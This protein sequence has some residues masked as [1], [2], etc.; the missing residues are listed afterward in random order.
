VDDGS[1][2][3]S[4]EIISSYANKV[5]PVLK[6]NGGQASAFNAGFDAS[7]GE[8]IIF[9]DADDMLYPTA[10]E[11][12]LVFFENTQ[13]V[14]VQWPLSIVDVES[15]VST[16]IEPS[17]IDSIDS[18]P[19][20]DLRDIVIKSGPS[21]LLSPPTSGN[22]WS[23]DFLL[24]VLPMDEKVYRM[25]ADAY[26]FEL[27]P[28]VGLI[29]TVHEPQ[30]YYR[31]HG[32]NH[33]TSMNFDQKLE[34]GLRM[35]N[36]YSLV[37]KKLCEKMDIHVDFNAWQANSWWCRFKRATNSLDTIVPKGE[38]FILVDDCT[39]GMQGDSVRH[40]IPFLE[41]DGEYWGPPPDSATAIQAL[42]KLRA[43]GICF[44]VI[45]WMSF[46]WL[47]YYT[48][49]SKYLH[50]HYS[51]ILEDENLIIFDLR[52]QLKKSIGV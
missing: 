51:C 14:K 30:A 1:T 37:A 19:E 26:L 49:F 5:N 29:R 34:F 7:C 12:A 22:A 21:N 6:D 43:S 42:E 39:W 31:V 40:P 33:H 46:W 48:D 24:R 18:L 8:V 2:D 17:N 35:Y 20:G 32:A 11:K 27:A 36:H 41:M 52:E 15:R 28:F 38:S 47:E 4:R 45:V 25:G 50:L 10:V 9:L 3:R 44:I 13:V 16:Q 23:R